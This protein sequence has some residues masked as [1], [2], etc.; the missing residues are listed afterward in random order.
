MK[1]LREIPVLLTMLLTGFG[2]FGQSTVGSFLKPADS[3]N[4]SRRNAVIISQAALAAGTYLALDNLWYSDY[5]KSDFHLVDDSAEWL[6]M[7]KAGHAFASYHLSRMSTDVFRWSGMNKNTSLIAG[8]VSGFVFVSAIE[9]FDGYSQRWGASLS[10]L[11]ANAAGSV[12][13]AGQELLWQEQRI[14]LKFSFHT[15]PYASARPEALGSSVSEQI[16]KD[17]NGQTY[18]VSVNLNSFL[19]SQSVPDWLNLAVGYGA[20]GMTTGEEFPPVNSV[21]YPEKKR[22]RQFYF[23]LDADLTRIETKSHLLKTLFSVVNTVKIPF[24]TLEF[25]TRGKAYFRPF[26]F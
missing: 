23:S 18:W 11:G 19:K 16:V 2:S 24:P 21:F 8:S 9:V 25:N 7:D 22:I 1:A 20:E 10:D 12:L 13:F 3:L 6:Q 17:Y 4:T 15:T 14:S 5:A 26:Y